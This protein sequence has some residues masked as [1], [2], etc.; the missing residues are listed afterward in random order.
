MEK[1]KQPKENFNKKS[2]KKN[3]FNMD[4]ELSPKDFKKI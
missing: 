2:F 3:F 4:D 1:Y